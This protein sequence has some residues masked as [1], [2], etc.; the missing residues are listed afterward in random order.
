MAHVSQGGSRYEEFIDC[1]EKDFSFFPSEGVSDSVTCCGFHKYSVHPPCIY[2]S[3]NLDCGFDL[4]FFLGFTV[5]LQR[6]T[7]CSPSVPQSPG[8]LQ[9]AHPSDVA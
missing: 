5:A 9:S 4:L 7:Q 3:Q 8:L 6:T 2:S 1:F